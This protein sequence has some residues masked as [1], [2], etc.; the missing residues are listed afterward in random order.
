MYYYYYYFIATEPLS[1]IFIPKF[2]P[3]PVITIHSESPSLLSTPPKYSTPQAKSKPYI[4]TV[5]FSSSSSNVSTPTSLQDS[6]LRQSS[7]TSS[8]IKT[9]TLYERNESYEDRRISLPI[10]NAAHAR[11]N[12]TKSININIIAN[13][14]YTP[15]AR[16]IR[17]YKYV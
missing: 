1:P 3:K 11:V 2:K 14:S 5:S 12:S 16:D 4:S 9:K 6:N 8:L 13:R 15:Q 10:L 7:S 17:A